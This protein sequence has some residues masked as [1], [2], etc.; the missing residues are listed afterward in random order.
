LSDVTKAAKAYTYPRVVK[1]ISS[2]VLDR[3]LSTF[4]MG[5][6]IFL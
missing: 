6:A 2:F 1:T 5:Y 4:S 3:E